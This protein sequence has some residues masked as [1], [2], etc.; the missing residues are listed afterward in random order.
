[1]SEYRDKEEVDYCVGDFYP[2]KIE[3]IVCNKKVWDF[4]GTILP[5]GSEYDC[6]IIC[7]KC[8][9]KIADPY[10]REQRSKK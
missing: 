9:I 6:E 5:Y 10:I 2:R 8:L 7:N 3:C 1:M 4:D